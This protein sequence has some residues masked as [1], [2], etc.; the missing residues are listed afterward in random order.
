[1]PEST[2]IIESSPIEWHNVMSVISSTKRHCNLL[3]GNGFSRAYDNDAFDWDSIV[4]LVEPQFQNRFHIDFK[5]FITHA[6]SNLETVIAEIE[7]TQKTL[8]YYYASAVKREDRDTI[9]KTQTLIDPHIGSIRNLLIRC[10]VSKHPD[11]ANRIS[12]ESRR[13]CFSF[14]QHFD[15]I[16]TLNYDLLTYWMILNYNEHSGSKRFNDGFSRRKTQK[17]KR[18]MINY[19]VN[20]WLKETTDTKAAQNVFFLHGAMHIYEEVDEKLRLLPERTRDEITYKL[21]SEQETVRYKILSLIT[22]FIDNYRIM[23]LVVVEGTHGNKLNRISENTY[24]Q[25][26]YNSLCSSSGTLTTYGVNFND[27]DSH[28]VDAILSSSLANV[29][30][31]IRDV[32]EWGKELAY[33]RSIK[34]ISNLFQHRY[35]LPKDDRPA[36]AMKKVH[37]YKQSGLSVWNR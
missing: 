14:L 35:M 22:K 34:R 4:D 33:T 28:I 31:G 9:Q 37:Y 27:N 29:Y 13:A 10:L 19:N 24:L 23:P 26:C 17:L 25:N 3:T 20:Q 36:R 11:T 2:L 7:Q 6:G 8:K 5:K 1:M 15:S 30:I 32:D 12:L 21:R 16:Y 18:W